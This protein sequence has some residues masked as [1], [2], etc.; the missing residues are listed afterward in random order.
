MIYNKIKIKFLIFYHLC[1]HFITFYNLLNQSFL[2]FFL[3]ESI[4]LLLLLFV[5]AFLLGSSFFEYAY[6]KIN[7]FFYPL[8]I[9]VII[10]GIF[11][12]GNFA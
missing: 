9:S 2:T 11:V 4:L 1:T 5:G 12:L 6:I 10:S 3:T 8:I 7:G